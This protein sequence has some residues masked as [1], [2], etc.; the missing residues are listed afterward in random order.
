[1]LPP[2]PEGAREPGEVLD[3]ID[4]LC[5]IG[6][7]DLGVDLYGSPPAHP[8]TGPKQERRDAFELALARRGAPAR[9]P[10]ARHLPRHAAPRRRRRRRPR[11]APRRHDRPHAASPGGRGVRAASGRDRVR[12]RGRPR[13]SATSVDGA[14]GPSP[15][16]R[17]RGRGARRSRLERP[18]ARSRRSRIP[19]TRSASACCGI[20]RRIRRAPGRRSSAGSSRQRAATARVR[21]R[22]ERREGRE[23]VRP[24]RCGVSGRRAPVDGAVL[25]RRLRRVWVGGGGGPLPLPFQSRAGRRTRGGRGRAARG[26]PFL[27]PPK[28]N[29]NAPKPNP[30]PPPPCAC[31][32][33]WIAANTSF[34][35]TPCA[36][37]IVSSRSPAASRLARSVGVSLSTP[38]A[39]S[40]TAARALDLLGQRREHG[41]SLPLRQGV[42]RDGLIETRLG[43]GDRGVADLVRRLARVGRGLLGGLERRE[44]LLE[45]GLGRRVEE[46]EERPG[47]PCRPGEPARAGR[48]RDAPAVWSCVVVPVAVVVPVVVV[49]PLSAPRELLAAATAPPPASAATA[50][51]TAN[52]WERL[53]DVLTSVAGCLLTACAR[54][55]TRAPPIRLCTRSS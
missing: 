38:A 4:G 54:I 42:V 52:P 53:M 25:R 36:W 30:R 27:P 50:S 12:R 44:G 41:G 2:T 29:P 37:A 17:A 9:S 31:C 35:A 8:E 33:F 55:L 43:R 20:P 32:A 23:A 46:A 22:G 47:E 51:A 34:R 14:L 21:S 15:G 16:R 7:P 48:I 19:S 13:C 45:R 49:E 24:C 3:A 39:A 28:P 6:G 40:M 5:L 11:T 18:T 10:G 26:S 1:M